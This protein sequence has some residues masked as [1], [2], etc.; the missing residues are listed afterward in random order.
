MVVQLDPKYCTGCGTVFIAKRATQTVCKKSC[1]RKNANESHALATLLHEVKFIGVDGE[2]VNGYRY[3]DTWN[4]ETAEFESRRVKTH[5]YVL[6]SVGNQSL[7]NNGRKL[8]WREIFPFL[9]EQFEANPHAAFV[10]FFLGYDFTHWLRDLP[11]SR[12]WKLLHKEGITSRSRRNAEVPNPRPW[13]VRCGMWEFDILANKRFMLRPF[14]PRDKQELVVVNHKDGTSTT[15]PKARPWLYVCDSGSFFQSSF[16]TAIDPNPKKWITPICSPEEYATIKTGKEH[17]ADAGFDLD[18]IRYNILENEILARLMKTV[19]EGLVADGIRLGKQQ[20]FGPGQA[21]QK[22]LGLVGAPPGELIRATVPDYA[23]DA[24]RESYYGGWF[25]IFA[26][27]IVPGRSFGYDIN[28]AYPYGISRLPCLLH[29]VW[30][31]GKRRSMRPLPDGSIRLVHAA[32]RGRDARV[33]A[34][35]F[36]RPDGTILRPLNTT[37]WYWWDELEAA[38]AAGVVQAVSVRDWIDYAP[39]DCPPPLGTIRDLYEGRLLVG[40]NSASG[41]GKKTIYNSAYGKLAQSVGQPKFTNAIYASRITSVCRTMIL[42]AIATHPNKTADLLMVATDS[43]VFKTPHPELDLDEER[44][45]AWDETIHNNLTLFMPGVYWDDASREKVARDEAPELKSRGISAKD[46]ARMISRID[47]QWR[48]LWEN[49][50]EKW[51]SLKLPVDFQMTTAKQA[52]VRGRW[53]TCGHV[54][55]EGFRK[56]SSDPTSK[57]AH[58]M[59]GGLRRNKSHG[60]AFTSPWDWAYDHRGNRLPNTTPYDKAFG[61]LPVNGE[62]VPITPDGDIVAL[63]QHAIIPRK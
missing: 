18:M 28:S 46:L 55:T 17:R 11:A 41:K 27:G 47:D 63:V 6:L 22:W 61:E 26:H 3:D 53:D 21:A 25:E 59:F 7:H 51:P 42:N 56:I 15:K 33:G 38:K 4:S 32:V 31:R 24:A 13:P 40:K 57:R 50:F 16:L 30:S 52:I 45:G 58:G 29:G 34:M 62:D 14:V 44:L 1:G 48:D 20:W 39:C 49:G 43:V 23:R 36:R 12:A 35:P 19:N 2:G 60:Y 5:D 9:W 37:G 10:G 54:D 8:S